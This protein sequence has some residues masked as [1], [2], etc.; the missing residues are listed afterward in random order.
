LA[1]SS[2][3]AGRYRRAAQP[4]APVADAS[5]T[6]SHRHA[7]ARRQSAR[8]SSAAARP[9]GAQPVLARGTSFPQLRHVPARARRDGGA[10][11]DRDG[12]RQPRARLRCASPAASDPGSGARIR[13]RFRLRVRRDRAAS[14]ASSSSRRR[15]GPRKPVT[16][17]RPSANETSSTAIT[18][19]NLLLSAQHARRCRPLAAVT[20][21]AS[22][23]SPPALPP[24]PLSVDGFPSSVRARQ[25]R[26]NE[27]VTRTRGGAPVRARRRSRYGPR[28]SELD[29]GCRDLRRADVGDNPATASSGGGHG[30][31]RVC[32]RALLR[33]AAAMGSRRGSNR[34]S[35]R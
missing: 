1:G 25:R 22:P 28:W 26:D 10:P 31:A 20:R 11:N 24:A 17:P 15:F 30:A 12:S 2:R 5:P 27:A 14:V 4:R 23:W 32:A 8:P 21:A 3:S 19:P 35:S 18:S 16:V 34:A 13:A 7:A 33:G 9:A 6:S 29:G